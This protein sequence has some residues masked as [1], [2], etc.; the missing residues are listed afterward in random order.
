MFI[1]SWKKAHGLDLCERVTGCQ[2]CHK[3]PYK[4]ETDNLN[5]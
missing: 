2:N 1:N 4:R 3:M 5:I